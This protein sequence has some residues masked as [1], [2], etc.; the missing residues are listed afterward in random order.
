MKNSGGKEQ[1]NSAEVKVGVDD[2]LVLRSNVV[3]QVW[4]AM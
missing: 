1:K 4:G 2:K 3:W